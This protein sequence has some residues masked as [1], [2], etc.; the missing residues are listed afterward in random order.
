MSKNIDNFF[1]P[2]SVYFNL[3]ALSL[4]LTNIQVMSLTIDLLKSDHFELTAD[5]LYYLC[6]THPKHIVQRTS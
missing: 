1:Y 5:T 6:V 3:S 2:N 4:A